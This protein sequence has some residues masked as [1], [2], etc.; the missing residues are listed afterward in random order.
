[1]GFFWGQEVR[2]R[3]GAPRSALSESSSKFHSNRGR[4]PTVSATYDSTSSS[5]TAEAFTTKNRSAFLRTPLEFRVYQ[6]KPANLSPEQ[7]TPA[8]K[9][10]LEDRRGC[11]HCSMRHPGP[12]KNQT[13][14]LSSTA[15]SQ[16]SNCW[17][18][19]DHTWR[20]SM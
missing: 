19:I 10:R 2:E 7:P 4:S 20:S 15:R 6:G 5:S 18:T 13:A 3:G 12:K 1:M 17:V 9:Q 16:P 8:P 11:R 14:T